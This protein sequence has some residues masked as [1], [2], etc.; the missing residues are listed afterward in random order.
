MLTLPNETN[1]HTHENTGRVTSLGL[2]FSDNQPSQQGSRINLKFSAHLF[3]DALFIKES[4]KDLPVVEE[5]NQAHIYFPDAVTTQNDTISWSVADQHSQ[6]FDEY[7]LDHHDEP[8]AALVEAVILKICTMIHH[9][10]NNN[11]ADYPISTDMIRF[12]AQGEPMMLLMPSINPEPLS[13][14]LKSVLFSNSVSAPE[15]HGHTC[16]NPQAFAFNVGMLAAQLLGYQPQPQTNQEQSLQALIAW[17]QQPPSN[18]HVARLQKIILQTL[19][20]N[21]GERPYCPMKIYKAITGTQP[22]NCQE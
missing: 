10:H 20:P 17:L 11:A 3:S 14:T 9:I 21:P 13:S 22:F 7:C 12:S 1:S 16:M 4:E 15:I 19:Q 5:L 8:D 2:F 18:N 6:S